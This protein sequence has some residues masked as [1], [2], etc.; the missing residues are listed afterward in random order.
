MTQFLSL[1]QKPGKYLEWELDQ[2]YNKFEDLVEA[3]TR[4]GQ[5]QDQVPPLLRQHPIHP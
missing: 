3:L 5:Q 2:G 4:N 1:L